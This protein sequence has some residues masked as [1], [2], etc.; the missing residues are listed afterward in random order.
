MEWERYQISSL[1]P[2]HDDGDDGGGDGDGDDDQV[3]LLVLI[4]ISTF[5][6]DRGVVGF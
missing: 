3:L 5:A 1:F 4:S 6:R 2:G